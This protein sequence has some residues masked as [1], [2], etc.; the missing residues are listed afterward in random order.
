[1][2]DFLSG[3]LFKAIDWWINIEKGYD[4]LLKVKFGALWFG[5]NF[6]RMSY[7]LGFCGTHFESSHFK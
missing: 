7:M 5:F 1:M 3:I 4:K 6:A 2:T